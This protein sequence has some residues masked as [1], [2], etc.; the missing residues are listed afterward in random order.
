MTRVGQSV[1][2]R[3]SA[4]NAIRFTWQRY[5]EGVNMGPI[6]AAATGRLFLLNREYAGPIPDLSP[7][8]DGFVAMAAAANDEYV[9]DETLVLQPGRYWFY[10][11]DQTNSIVASNGNRDLYT[12]GEMYALGPNNRFVVYFPNGVTTER[13]DANFVLRGR[14][15]Q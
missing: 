12:D 7:S 14:P 11:N 13:V 2:I 15:V 4:F 1:T 8:V 6:V 5:A 9:F 10:S 3:Q